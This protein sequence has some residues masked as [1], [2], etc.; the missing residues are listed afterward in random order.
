MLT[1]SIGIAIYDGEET[2]HADLLKKAEIAMFRAK[3]AGADRIEVFT[4]EEVAGH[5]KDTIGGHLKAPMGTGF[6]RTLHERP[7]AEWRDLGNGVKA[8]KSPWEE[9]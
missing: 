8:W 4:P 3:R 6:G 7:A 1:G 5:F 9:A 2:S